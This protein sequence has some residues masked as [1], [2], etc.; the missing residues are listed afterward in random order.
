MK[1]DF[2]TIGLRL[3]GE[4]MRPNTLAVSDLSN[5]S[6]GLEEAIIAQIRYE[7][8]ISNGEDQYI[9]LTQINEGS[10]QLIYE[11]K[12]N[13]IKVGFIKIVDATKEDKIRR[14]GLAPQVIDFIETSKSFAKKRQ[15][16]VYLEANEN[17]VSE[18]T[19]STQIE[20]AK[21]YQIKDYSTVYAEVVRVGGPV[22]PHVLL[23]FDQEPKPLS[24]EVTKEQGIALGKLLYKTVRLRGE[25]VIDTIDPNNWKLVSFT[26]EEVLP[27][28]GDNPSLVFD[29]LRLA[30]GKA[31][32]AEQNIED[33]LNND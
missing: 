17:L 3:H 28:D 30:A 10:A 21:A 12:S 26:I 18:I 27:F 25:S 19:P 14:R 11:P 31:W 15:C 23:K 29:K 33:Y 22:N 2:Q 13:A 16:I 6:K 8:L 9:S 1:N 20:D 4:G 7:G 5:L 32:D 24:V